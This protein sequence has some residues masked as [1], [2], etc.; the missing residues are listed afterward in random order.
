MVELIC[1]GEHLDLP[2]DFNLTIEDTNPIFNDAG[3]MSIP[4]SIPATEKNRR[5]LCFPERPDGIMATRNLIDVTVYAGGNAYDAKLNILEANET[6]ISFN[7]GFDNA[8]LYAEWLNKS[9]T[10][11]MGAKTVNTGIDSAYNF[12]VKVSKSDD[13]DF[14]CF[15]IV[16]IEDTSVDS[17]GWWMNCYENP[18]GRAI[19]EYDRT[20]E[21]IKTTETIVPAGYG[22][23]VFP[24]AVHLLRTIFSQIG[25]ECSGPF[26]DIVGI[27]KLVVLNN[28][29]DAC[30]RRELKYADLMPDCTVGE[31]LH[32]VF[33]KFGMVY[34]IDWTNKKAHIDYIRNIISQNRPV[35]RELR[36][37]STSR[38]T[39]FYDEAQYV[40]LK[41]STSLQGA[42]PACERYEDFV[43]GMEVA[44]ISVGEAVEKW[45]P[46]NGTK[47]WDGDRNG[48]DWDDQ[49]HDDRDWEWDY[50]DRWDDY[51]DHDDGA[52]YAPPRKETGYTG[53]ETNLL[54]YEWVTGNWALLDFDN[55]VPVIQGSSFFSWSPQTPGMQALALDSV[56]EAVPVI[57]ANYIANHK[58]LPHFSVGMR[59]YHTFIA[60]KGEECQSTPLAFLL[61]NFRTIGSI[62]FHQGRNTI[63]RDDGDCLGEDKYFTLYH[64]FEDGLFNVFWRHFDELLRHG[65]IRYELEAKLD[66][67]DFGDILDVV[68]IDGARALIDTRSSTFVANKGIEATIFL[69]LT[70]PRGRYDIRQEQGVPDFW[71]ASR[72]I[73]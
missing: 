57:A 14:V 13:Y 54:A 11:V 23:T 53:D 46:V 39:M 40:T 17:N 68:S 33:V 48:I 27:R 8:I 49:D 67:T 2:N 7:V 24:R 56:D 52:Y 25:I 47:M 35:D 20:E 61:D 29:A 69:R 34:T 41:N 55:A 16:L 28:C 66:V 42:A 15:P 36:P 4:T 62:S 51:Y 70:E 5:L 18:R 73:R 30:V 10:E 63:E 60:N 58:Y 65:M 32:A 43:K 71:A 72:D 45:K 1:K 50:D 12:A 38:G 59:H 6:S 9:L 37:L 44:S 3:T 31:F 22:W 26:F 19:K 64:Q 21:V